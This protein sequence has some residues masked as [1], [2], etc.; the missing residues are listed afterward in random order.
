MATASS[1]R[2]RKDINKSLEKLVVSSG[3]E[4]EEK[5]QQL[6]ALDRVVEEDEWNAQREQH[7]QDLL[8]QDNSTIAPFWQD[9]YEQEASKNWDLFYQRNTINFYKDRHYIHLVFPEILTTSATD[10][11]VGSSCRL[12]NT[13][14]PQRKTFLEIGCGVGNAFLP[15]I[16][17]NPQLDFI[18]VDFSAKAISLLQAKPE[19]DS[20][21]CTALVCDITKLDQGQEEIGAGESLMPAASAD[22]ALCLFCMSA[23]N[24]A[25]MGLAAAN[26]FRAMKPGGSLLFRDYGQFDQAQMRFKKGHKLM[27]NFYIR[28][29]LTR[30][31][32]FTTEKVTEI[33]EQAGFQVNECSY[34]RRRFVNRKQNM[35]RFRVWIHAKFTKPSKDILDEQALAP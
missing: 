30:A 22:Y 11:L 21:R 35:S 6:H 18:A 29:D 20:T 31:Y 17:L 25:K 19:F 3:V 15:L 12:A 23:I 5:N 16:S 13:E 4:L 2:S 1:Y 28:Q 9:K 27:D 14:Q 26:I 8:A 7:A 10:E 34:I 32:Y 24:P 33:F